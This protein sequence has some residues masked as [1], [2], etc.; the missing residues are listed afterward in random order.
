MF[1]LGTYRKDVSP[2]DHSEIFM[3]S[4]ITKE[5]SAYRSKTGLLEPGESRL[6]NEGCSNNNPKQGSKTDAGEPV[7]R[8]IDARPQARL[9]DHSEMF[10]VFMLLCHELRSP[11]YTIRNAVHQFKMDDISK[12]E[13]GRFFPILERNVDRM[14]NLVEKGLSVMSAESGHASGDVI[15]DFR[16][17]VVRAVD[18]MKR[19][20]HGHNIRLSLSPLLPAQL[21][22]RVKPFVIEQCVVCLIANALQYGC[23]PGGKNAS[24]V[25]ICLSADGEHAILEVKDYGPGL[26][27]EEQAQL[28][29]LLS[30]CEPDL[31]NADSTY[32]RRR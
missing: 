23:V 3:Q 12:D 21:P 2:L 9:S 31:K 29:T 8:G 5:Q 7:L 30:N 6:S 19:D 28:F 18:S 10:Y 16:D 25:D 11:L 32:N 15:S 17:S 24:I 14:V 13:S 20:D 27:K 26:S 1:H 22:V 4:G